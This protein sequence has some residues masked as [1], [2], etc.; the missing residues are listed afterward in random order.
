M[1]NPSAFLLLLAA[2]GLLSST[3]SAQW[4]STTIT[5]T[6]QIGQHYVALGGTSENDSIGCYGPTGFCVNANGIGL[7]QFANANDVNN[8]FAALQT[9]LGVQNTLF[10]SSLA[11]F[12][13]QL[14]GTNATVTAFQ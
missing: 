5:T 14:C 1:K 4:A 11:S 6:P 10:N 2:S 9:Q 13:S 8:S 7:N 3:A 12:Q